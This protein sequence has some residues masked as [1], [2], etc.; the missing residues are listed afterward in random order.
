MS[1]SIEYL[2]RIDVDDEKIILT[3]PSHS[4]Y[5]NIST[6]VKVIGTSSFEWK[7]KLDEEKEF[8]IEIEQENM[9]IMRDEDT[10]E[11]AISSTFINK[12]KE[13]DV[14]VIFVCDR[15]GSM[16]REG[17]TNL[18]EMLQL[19]LRQLPVNSKFDIVSFGN[20]FDFMFNEMKEYN[21]EIMKKASLEVSK[22]DSNFQGT[23]MSK[24]LQEMINK[25]IENTHI[26][27]LTDGEDFNKE[28]VIQCVEELSKKNIIHGVGLGRNCDMD[29]MR[30][31]SKIGKGINVH[32]QDPNTLGAE[33]S[34]ITEKILIP[35]ILN[36][37]KY[38]NS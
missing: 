36:C 7:G 30:R 29:L 34:K 15:S 25:H 9:M 22:F 14:N 2:T 17:I 10:D 35:S 20:R 37:H 4:E 26:I 18:K 8:E 28:Q 5:K 11:V 33:V 24:P 32:A 13:A 31:C 1:F 21:E 38:C 12:E 6:N 3:I 27:L 23:E 16:Y 19:F